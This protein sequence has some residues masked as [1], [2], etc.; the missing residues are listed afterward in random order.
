M[1]CSDCE[2]DLTVEIVTRGIIHENESLGPISRRSLKWN[3]EIKPSISTSLTVVP[4]SS[5]NIYGISDPEGC[6]D[7]P[8]SVSVVKLRKK[9][10]SP[11]TVDQKLSGVETYEKLTAE[12][13]SISRNIF[14]GNPSNFNEVSDAGGCPEKTLPTSS[15]KS[16][17]KYA[18]DKIDPKSRGVETGKEVPAKNTSVSTSPIVVGRSPSNL[19]DISGFKGCAHQPL[20]A[21]SKK[22]P[23]RSGLPIHSEQ[24]SRSVEVVKSDS[25][26]LTNVVDVVSHSTNIEAETSDKTENSSVAESPL[27]N[28]TIS[29]CSARLARA[30]F[31]E[32]PKRTRLSKIIFSSDD[33]SDVTDSNSIA[34]A[35]SKDFSACDQTMHSPEAVFDI[36]K[37]TTPEKLSSK[38]P[39]SH[40]KSSPASS[41]SPCSIGMLFLDEDPTKVRPPPKKN[42]PSKQVTR[43]PA[44]VELLN[45]DG[46]WSSVRDG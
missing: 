32:K 44:K 33:H 16:G 15:D 46:L 31:G 39:K 7:K 17:L 36:L 45:D 35:Q 23:K 22:S 9:S 14:Q 34:R 25:A 30:C 27:K 42:S 19:F 10:L 24:E 4:S 11:V 38:S 28:S 6:A 3:T 18:V 40:P 5:S 43:S 13:V 1:V 20:S 2:V 41:S 26:K 8:L 29:P 37:T 12:N 21:S